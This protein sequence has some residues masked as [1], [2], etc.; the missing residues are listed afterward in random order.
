VVLRGDTATLPGWRARAT[1][2]YAPR[3]LTLAIPGEAG[4]LPSGLAARVAPAAGCLAYVCRG[5]HCESP[6]GELA[7]LDA[8]L[9]RTEAPRA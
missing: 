6:I 7:S 1:A 4:D 8:A 2:R 5:T 9:A 3:R